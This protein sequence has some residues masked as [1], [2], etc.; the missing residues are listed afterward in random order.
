MMLLL[1]MSSAACKKDNF[2]NVTPKGSLTDAS[3]FS[4]ESNA[5][6][7]VNDIYNQLPDMNNED[8][9]LDQYT[10]NDFVGAT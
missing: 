3:T 9:V 4:S 1:I 7:F 2:L 10:D 6:L 8:Q 5:D